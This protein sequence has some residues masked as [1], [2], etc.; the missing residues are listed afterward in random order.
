MSQ[1]SLTYLFEEIQRLRFE[2]YE[3][4]GIYKSKDA[5]QLVLA[6]QDYKGAWNE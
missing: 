4:T 2:V 6:K 1:F 3:A 5:N